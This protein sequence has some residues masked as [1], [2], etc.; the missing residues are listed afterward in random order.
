MPDWFL[1]VCLTGKFELICWQ[2]AR[3][4]SASE[5]KCHTRCTETLLTRSL[6]PTSKPLRI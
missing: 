6:F 2:Q 5:T 1:A 4:F 3:Q